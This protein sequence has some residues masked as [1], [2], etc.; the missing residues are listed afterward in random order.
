MNVKELAEAFEK[1]A[2][3][4]KVLQD[5]PVIFK[6]PTPYASDIPFYYEIESVTLNVTD[7]TVLIEG[8]ETH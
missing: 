4:E 1:L 5:C 2:K 6:D 3:D 8:K 7:G